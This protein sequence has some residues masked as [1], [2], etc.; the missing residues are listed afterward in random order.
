MLFIQE[1]IQHNE[2]AEKITFSK[3]I[4]LIFVIKLKRLTTESILQNGKYCEVIAGTHKGKLGSVADMN[5]SKTGNITITVVQDDGVRFKTLG[6]NVQVLEGNS[7]SFDELLKVVKLSAPA[8]RALKLAKI[9]TTEELTK[10]TSEE[11]LNLHGI[12]PTAIPKLEE[13]LKVNVRKK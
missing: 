11:L 13:L 6:K 12:G 4:G 8:Q 3:S 2:V 5:T 7:L 1:R 10:W 9:T